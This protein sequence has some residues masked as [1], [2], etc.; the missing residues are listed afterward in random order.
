MSLLKLLALLNM[1]FA[2]VTPDIFQLLRLWL[3]I[4]ASLNKFNVLVA[5]EVS[6]VPMGPKAAG[7]LAPVDSQS[8]NLPCFS[9]I[10]SL[11][12]NAGNVE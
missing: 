7:Q 6:H 11:L 5:S 1:A 2:F 4:L 10:S 8:R 12:R 3:N 9:A